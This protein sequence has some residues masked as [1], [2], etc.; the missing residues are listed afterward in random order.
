MTMSFKNHQQQETNRRLVTISSINL[1]SLLA[2]GIDTANGG[3]LAID[4][5]I[6]NA[7]II[8]YPVVGENWYVELVKGRWILGKKEITASQGYLN[9]NIDP[10]DQ[11]WNVVDN[12]YQTVSGAI[13]QTVGEGV[14][15]SVTQGFSQ[16]VGQNFTRT[17]GGNLTQTVGGNLTETITGTFSLTDANGTLTTKPLGLA[18][19]QFTEFAADTSVIGTSYQWPAGWGGFGLVFIGPPSGLVEIKFSSRMYVAAT[20]FGLLSP[21]VSTGATFGSGTSILAT[22]DDTALQTAVVG[23]YM[24]LSLVLPLAV[25]PGATY[26]CILQGRQGGGA[27]TVHFASTRL[28]IDPKLH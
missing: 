25:N 5:S 17:V 3:T 28:M 11:V 15:E 9:K 16:S 7:P 8:Q 13:T 6:F 26:N 4:L 22:S 18:S 19:Y 21:L 20:G 2:N 23:N 12:L 24:T 10:G 27:G 14:T 1:G